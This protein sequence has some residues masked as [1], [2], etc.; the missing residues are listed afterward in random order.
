ME[1]ELDASTAA[2][3]ERRARERGQPVSVF[4]ANYLKSTLADED[5]AMQELSAFLQ[6][7]IEEARRGEF[8][9]QSVEEIF[10]E[11]FAETENQNGGL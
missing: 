1:I 10:E 2:T 3:L 11:A 9:D 6:P 8:V 7:R 4:T 5:E